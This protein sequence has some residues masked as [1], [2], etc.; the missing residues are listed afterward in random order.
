MVHNQLFELQKMLSRN[1]ILISFSGRFSQKIIEEL[2]D[3]LKYYLEIEERPKNDIFQIFSIFIEQTQNIKNYCESK[4]GSTHYDRIANACMVTIGNYAE[5]T[6][7]WSGNIIQNQDAIKLQNLLDQL[8]TLDKPSI[9][10]LYKEKLRQ[11]LPEGSTS[12]GIGL[13]DMA[14]KASQPLQYEITHIDEDYSFF[15]L[16]ALV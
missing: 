9:K 2:G 13:I 11:E 5:G 1:G 14:K 8:I 3:A 4:Q 6:Y 10:K 16:K 12:A 15:T 7:V